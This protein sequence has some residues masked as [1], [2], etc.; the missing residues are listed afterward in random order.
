MDR[1]RW[2]NRVQLVAIAIVLAVVQFGLVQHAFAAD[3]DHVHVACAYCV[4]G[5]HHSP[6]PSTSGSAATVPANPRVVDAILPDAAVAPAR[7][8]HLV[9]GP[10]SIT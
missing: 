2:L 3:A 5:D 9:R 7:A 8:A 10:P 4:A 1:T 6:D